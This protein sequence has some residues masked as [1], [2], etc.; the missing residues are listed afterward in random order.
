MHGPTFTGN[1][2]ACA[3]ANASL[4]L[5]ETQPRLEQVANI[6]VQLRERLSGLIDQ[7]SVTAVNF[8]G[9]VGAVRL[10]QEIDVQ[11]AIGQFVD[12][13]VWIR[14]IRDTVYLAPAF[15]ISKSELNVL[16][17]AVIEWVS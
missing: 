9:A 12:R 2:I 15:T 13:G 5:F 3:A 7:D 11:K 17:D 14:P 8:C 4:D 16:C 6:E 10:Q 1:P